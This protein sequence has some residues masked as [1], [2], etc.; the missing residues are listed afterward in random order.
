[1]RKFWSRRCPDCCGFILETS[2]KHLE[3]SGLPRWKI[4]G[5]APAF[6]QWGEYLKT[7][8]EHS[9]L[10][11]EA[12]H[13]RHFAEFTRFSGLSKDYMNLLYFLSRGS[14]R[15]VYTAPECERSIASS[16]LPHQEL[17]I[18]YIYSMYEVQS[19]RPTITVVLHN[20]STTKP[21]GHAE[22]LPLD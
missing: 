14:Y 5:N 1:M 8:C 22:T 3:C 18:R 15:P 6:W 13:R 17:A 16:T 21:K 2:W 20:T 12:K 7:C 10:K 19:Y 11:L 4:P 9:C